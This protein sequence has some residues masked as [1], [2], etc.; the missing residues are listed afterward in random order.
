M[1]PDGQYHLAFSPSVT[2]RGKDFGGGPVALLF[3]PA[4]DFQM[5][6]ELRTNDYL[7]AIRPDTARSV[8]RVSMG[9]LPRVAAADEADRGAA[10]AAWAKL[11]ETG[12]TL[13]APY[14]VCTETA[15][16]EVGPFLTGSGSYLQSLMFGLTGLRLRE[17]GL[18]Q[19]Y[20]PALPPGWRSLTLRDVSFRGRRL[21]I[22]ITRDPT[23]AVRLTGL[24]RGPELGR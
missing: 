6:A 12:G 19:A 1:A 8:G 3:L 14:D 2:T 23:G 11:F 18:V 16:N 5:P 13:K 20:S 24:P 22:R 21:T 17:A 9:I 4:L 15:A 10:A 7:H